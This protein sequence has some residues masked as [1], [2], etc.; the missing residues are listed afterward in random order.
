MS[1]HGFIVFATTFCAFIKLNLARMAHKFAG[2]RK[3][4]WV[5]F[6]VIFLFL[7]N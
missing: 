2:D 4:L 3:T 1:F 7:Y 6:G 5:L